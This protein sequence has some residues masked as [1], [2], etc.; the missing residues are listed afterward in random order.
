MKQVNESQ[1]Q[2]AMTITKEIPLTQGKVALIDAED[3]ER[4]SAFKWRASSDPKTG[5][6]LALRTELEGYTTLLMHRFILNAP[7]GV[8]V[9][10]K[11][12]DRLNN[13]RANIRL[14]TQ[15]QNVAAIGPKK[16]CRYKGIGEARN[17]RFVAFIQKDHQ[18][19]YLGTFDTAVEAATVYDRWA[20]ELHE[21]FAYQNFPPSQGASHAERE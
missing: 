6:F 21:E 9:D 13:T 3:Y 10:H 8:Q 7:E 2:T 4:V 12:G 17:G 14:C 15:S 18:R 1:S 16:G 19:R 20:R 11:D 5:K